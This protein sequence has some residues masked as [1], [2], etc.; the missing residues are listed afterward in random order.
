MSETKKIIE[1]AGKEE[2][3]KLVE[4]VN[5]RLAAKI[6]KSQGTENA[7]KVLGIG[8]D[9]AVSPIDARP[10]WNENDESNPSFI[11][12][13][14]FGEKEN[15]IDITG[16]EC[17]ISNMTSH[18]CQKIIAPLQ[19]GQ[20]WNIF[21][22][23]L[24]GGIATLRHENLEVKIDEDGTCYLGDLNKA[25]IPF[26]IKN[27]EIYFNSNFINQLQ[28]SIFK[29]VGVSGTY[30]DKPIIHHLDPKYIKDMYYDT[31]QEKIVEGSVAYCGNVLMGY[32]KIAIEENLWNALMADN[33]VITVEGMELKRNKIADGI[34]YYG[35][36]DDGYTL[37]AFVDGKYAYIQDIS[38]PDGT[39]TGTKTITCKYSEGRLQQIDPKYIKDMYYEYEEPI[40]ESR[41]FSAQSSEGAELVDAEFARLL[42]D[43]W[44]NAI[45]TIGDE[46]TANVG[47]YV[48]ITDCTH[49]SSYNDLTLT[50]NTV[51]NDGSD[52]T[53]LHVHIG[54]DSGT[55]TWGDHGVG[56]MSNGTITVTSKK[57]VKTLDPKYLPDNLQNCYTIKVIDHELTPEEFIALPDGYYDFFKYPL[58]IEG[59]DGVASRQVMGL[60][61]LLQFDENVKGVFDYF[62]GW[63]Y[64]TGLIEEKL[65]YDA[66][67]L[68]PMSE[69]LGA[70]MEL[71]DYLFGSVIGNEEISTEDKTLTGAINEINSKLDSHTHSL[72]ELEA[73]HSDWNQND[74]TQPNYVENRTH[75]RSDLTDLTVAEG[76][77]VTFTYIE[78]MGAGYTH[79]GLSLENGVEYTL[80]LD[81]NTSVHT[82]KVIS[83]NYSTYGVSS[84]MCYVGNAC[85]LDPSLDLEDTGENY[86]LVTPMHYD[87]DSTAHYSNNITIIT[88]DTQDTVHTYKLTKK[89]YEYHTLAREYLPEDAILPE[90]K[91]ASGNEII[92]YDASLQKWI[93]TQETCQRGTG[94]ASG[95][96][97]FANGVSGSYSL[98]VGQYNNISNFSST[99][100]GNGLIARGKMQHV[101]GKYNIEDSESKYVHIVGNG[102][103]DTAR[104]N[105]HTLDWSGNAEYAGDVKANACGGENPV[106][107]VEVAEKV[108][109]VKE[110]FMITATLN[111]ST[112]TLDK[113]Y[114]DITTA[115]ESGHL[116]VVYMS[117][118]G[119]IIN[120]IGC[121]SGFHTFATAIHGAG[122]L[123]VNYMLIISD[124]EVVK[125]KMEQFS[126]LPLATSANE[127][128]ILSVVNGVPTWI[129]MPTATDS[130]V[131]TML[132]ELG[133]SE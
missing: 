112:Y 41:E 38:A 32:D 22:N 100:F 31:L 89:G 125:Y 45:F 76:T 35:N 68:Y 9:G 14:P 124:H 66:D 81:G 55:I 94:Y 110:V 65:V 34:V 1:Y 42:Y 97:G 48:E 69:A 61:C 3:D 74:E 132:T 75:W 102:K 47:G 56:R 24:N 4:N 101:Q 79:E 99:A 64:A 57:M 114:T 7:N 108:N 120:Y 18:T 96:I 78:G 40:T 59:T 84:S 118:Q 107:L 98:A 70:F 17:E 116:P 49:A 93:L 11:Q 77:D 29:I 53:T 85:L 106:S 44:E 80:T 67:S 51:T 6:N 28:P 52:H 5:A 109:N 10:N 12:N 21:Y 25:N 133:L 88:N 26:Y 20:I 123:A 131:T 111:G 71:E 92:K 73:R 46:S 33:C 126:T 117:D 37:N 72:T 122:Q 103:N 39:V 30:T 83:L 90:I 27:N 58:T 50:V 115:I 13:R 95:H 86:V 91:N 105:A 36:A 23:S 119:M 82:A 130:E 128:Q 63:F 8:S 54:L 113:T 129:D 15:K 121:Q 43:N 19:L 62:T 2:I 104:S 127:G 60:V 16:L 87:S